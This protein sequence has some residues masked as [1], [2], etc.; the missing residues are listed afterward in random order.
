L[1]RGE[2]EDA[3]LWARKSVQTP[4]AQYWACAH[5]VSALGHIGDTSE[6]RSAVGDLLQA[7]PE[8]SIAFAREHLFY[9]KRSD[10]LDIYLTGLRKAGIT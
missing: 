8:F 1:F 6:M 10:Q 3:A 5:L 4:N 7:K 2:F 9:I